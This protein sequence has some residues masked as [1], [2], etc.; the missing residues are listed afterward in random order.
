MAVVDPVVTQL[1]VKSI[2]VRWA[3]MVDNDTGGPV[4]LPQHA[5]KTVQVIGVF[6]VGGDVD[7]EGSTETAPASDEWGQLH[8]P[9]GTIISIGDRLPLVISENT[10]TIRPVIA[11]GDGTTLLDVVIIAT[12]RV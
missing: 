8:D 7:L 12:A 2:E 10:R 11:G 3:A 1:D 6:G 5:D 4:A 9:Q